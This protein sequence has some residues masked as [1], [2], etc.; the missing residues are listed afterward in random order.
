M[1]RVTSNKVGDGWFWG[2]AT[3]ITAFRKMTNINVVVIEK[4]K[5]V[6]IQKQKFVVNHIREGN[7]CF[8]G[9]WLYRVNN[10]HYRIIFPYE[11]TSQYRGIEEQFTRDHEPFNIS[12]NK[13]DTYQEIAGI[14]K[15]AKQ[16][17]EARMSLYAVSEI[18]VEGWESKID[19]FENMIVDTSK[20]WTDIEPEIYKLIEIEG[21]RNIN[22]HF[23]N[24]KPKKTKKRVLLNKKTKK[25]V[26]LNKKTKKKVL[27]NKKTKKKSTFK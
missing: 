8:D 6:V 16:I 20:K 1:I 23:N 24:K 17:Q 13:Y 19:N 3:I 15:L 26:L 21:G 2:D 7:I 18:D 22:M 25:K 10:N 14:D 9:I 11:V 5:F 4:Q 12:E 27:L